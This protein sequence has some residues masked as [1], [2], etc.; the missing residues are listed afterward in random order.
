MST[1]I[2][3]DHPDAK[4]KNQKKKG[5]ERRTKETTKQNRDAAG[6]AA[7]DAKSVEEEAMPIKTSLALDDIRAVI[8]SD[9]VREGHVDETRP[10][11]GI[12]HVMT[13]VELNESLLKELI[14][15]R[16]RCVQ[17]ISENSYHPCLV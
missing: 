1:G 9:S 4:E 14:V 2:L 5:E 17:K 11:Q 8:V 6:A 13:Q 3:I 12:F 7:E 15:P 10:H 16:K